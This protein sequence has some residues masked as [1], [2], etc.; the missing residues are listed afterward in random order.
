MYVAKLIKFDIIVAIA[1]MMQINRYL[2]T[3]V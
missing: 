3:Y 2:A 1:T